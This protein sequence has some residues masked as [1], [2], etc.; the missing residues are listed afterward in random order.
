LNAVS[1]AREET[2]SLADQVKLLVQAFGRPARVSHEAKVFTNPWTNSP[3]VVVL[4]ENT[5]VTIL[6][7]SGKWRLVT[8]PDSSI[9][10]PLK[11]GWVRAKYLQAL[12]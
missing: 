1:E 7:R 5:F 10:G 2:A 3:V 12:N 9:S 11:S 6:K 4:Q 8:W